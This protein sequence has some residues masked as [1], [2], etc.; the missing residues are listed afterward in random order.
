MKGITFGMV[1]P[2]TTCCDQKETEEDPISL[3]WQQRVR[4]CSQSVLSV[5]QCQQHILLS[6]ILY[7]V[8]L[9]WRT[10]THSVVCK[11]RPY[12]VVPSSRRKR[13]LFAKRKQISLVRRRGTFFSL[14]E[15]SLHLSS[16]AFFFLQEN[17]T[18]SGRK[19]EENH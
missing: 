15:G 14:C 1:Y 4:H 18:I 3:D 17:E 7:P 2:I 9:Q 16:K 5:D 10:L 11:T 12:E 6:P 8:I 13:R 19:R